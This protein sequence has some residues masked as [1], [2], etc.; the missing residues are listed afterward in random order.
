MR[1]WVPGHVEVQNAASSGIG[2]N[3]AIFTLVNAVMLKSLPVK[4][5]AELYRLGTADNC[6]VIGSFQDNWGIYFYPL[7]LE[8]RDSI[9]ELGDLAAFQGGLTDLSVRRSGAGGPAEPFEG[10]LFPETIFRPLA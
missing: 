3:T 2:A 8:F 1:G 9:P 7:Y 5:P 4:N 10:E 6:C